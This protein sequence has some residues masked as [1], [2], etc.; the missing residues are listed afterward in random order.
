MPSDIS[1]LLLQPRKHYADVRLQQGRAL[2]D[3]D[4]NEGSQL[5]EEDRRQA[6]LDL[7]G[8][9]GTPDDG[10]SLGAPLIAGSPVPPQTD[11]LP[12]GH[13]L[14]TTDVQLGGQTVAVIPLT[15]RA[16]T[17]YVGGHRLPLEQ[18]EPFV[19]QRDFLQLAPPE[20]LPVFDSGGGFNQFYYL[21]AWEQPVSSVED[22]EIGEPMLRGPDV[23]TRVRTMRRARLLNLDPTVARGC[24][25]GFAALKAQLAADN[26]TVDD[27]TFEVLSNGR[28][29][30]AFD[31]GPSSDTC[32]PCA[33]NQRRYLGDE[34]AALRIMLTDPGHFVWAANDATPLFAVRVHNLAGPGDVQIEMLTPP[35]NEDQIP[36][37]G[38]VVELLPFAALLGGGDL[39]PSLETGHFKKVAAEVGAFTRANSAIDPITRTFTVED[40]G[41]FRA[42]VQAFV[43]SWDPNHPA[44]A[45]LNTPAEAPGVI[46]LYMRLWHVAADASGVLIPTPTPSGGVDPTGPAL[47]DTGVIPV[48]M[49]PG[50]RGDFWVAALR[51]D[52]PGLVVPYDLRTEPAGVPPHGPHHFVAP[53]AF[54]AGGPSGFLALLDDCRVRMR[55]VTDDS[56]ITITVGDG[57]ASV[58]DQTSIQA[59]VDLLPSDGGRIAVRPG[60]YT[61][62]VSV[63][64]RRNVSIE[65]C[66]NA[67]IIRNPSGSPSGDL[68]SI[69]RSTGVTL[70]GLALEVANQRGVGVSASND[71]VLEDLSVTAGVIRAG[72]FTPGALA[73]EPALIE[74][75]GSVSVKVQGVTC[76]TFQRPAL[77]AQNSEV[78]SVRDLTAGGDQTAGPAPDEPL[79]TFTACRLV[80]VR[81]TR[82]QT[83][84]QVALAIRDASSEDVD[85]AGLEVGAGAATGQNAADPRTGVDIEAGQRISVT[86]SLIQMAAA[87]SEHA[88]IVVQGNDV[89]IVRNR[90]EADT[91]C[92][93]HGAAC[94]A[95]AWGGIQIRGGSERIEVRRNRIV[96]GVGHGITLGSVLWRPRRSPVRSPTGS[97]FINASR[98]EGA[99]R[100]QLGVQGTA[101]VIAADIGDGFFD[102]A[103]DDDFL[104]FSEGPIADLAIEGNRIEGMFSSG[105]SVL[106]VLG[107][108][109][110]GGDLIE[111]VQARIE[112]NTVTGN[113]LFPGRGLPVVGNLFPFPAATQGSSILVQSL[114]FGAVVL[115]A[116]SGGLD[117][118]N[119]RLTGNGSSQVLPTSGIFVLVGDGISISGNRITANGDVAA[120]DAGDPSTDLDP[121]IRAGIAVM[122]AG[123]GTAG[124]LAAL[125]PVLKDRI[126][127]DP[128][129][130]ALRVIDNTV[131]QKE[132]RALHVVATGPVTVEGNYLGSLGFHG[133]DN[134]VDR[135][136]IGDV[137]YVQNLGGPWER[138]GVAAL[139]P[140][141]VPNVPADVEFL[142][143][144]VP[145]RTRPYLTNSAP[146]SPRFFAGEGGAVVFANNQVVYDFT[147]RRPVPD[148]STAPVSFFPVALLC[149]DHVGVTGN[150]FGLRFQANVEPP[151]PPPFNGLS[152][153]LGQVLAIGATVNVTRNR[154]SAGVGTVLLSLVAF[155]QIMGVMAANQ[156]THDIMI[157]SNR[158][159]ESP[160]DVQSDTN[161]VLLT[162]GSGSTGEFR[163]ILQAGFV[164]L[165]Q[166][167]N[168]ADLTGI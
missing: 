6:A 27:S 76:L 53:L 121:G 2:I 54:M 3:S 134:Q 119:N 56:C 30:I 9:T 52:T 101:L 26:A 147:L 14:A 70:T 116:A 40:D 128:E 123:T 157:L 144:V 167:P 135:F 91:S 22:P 88:G 39:P 74:V 51:V 24:D 164:K 32:A 151:E 102:D 7:I 84:G 108:R 66:G 47:G 38:R 64:G 114:P 161:Q 50:R 87:F 148:G 79:V 5:R 105:I 90:V 152:Q 37:P 136:A 78:V 96:G 137:V 55:K 17:M 131:M 142:N 61:E 71:V 150:Q 138:F 28:L 16:G 80:S 118:R 130:S 68:V 155:D 35:G 46:D 97:P 107:F 85:V 73:A 86:D 160:F 77:L 162:S 94:T 112:N 63:V 75:D 99:G 57:V 122:L 19:F 8:P 143:Y 48:F 109:N 154:A 146:A 145:G 163:P 120:S 25:A 31:A 103:S 81:Q 139:S 33:P 113:L 153:I 34:N 11:P 100:A 106:T 168:P 166:V 98:R 115:A 129:G 141:P 44:A 69:V 111:V 65:G 93:D 159:L 21:E 4:L 92:L 1:R 60:V 117:I 124:T 23:A 18:P 45:R 149:L 127:S 13:N 110:L 165:L 140:S 158:V 15:L 89:V 49:T 62:T 82:L 156:T 95:V 67:T 29:R 104:P 58:G 12:V 83:F 133:A 132:G 10:F 20:P 72:A 36:L 126:A 42:A 125:S 41:G 43:T 59:A